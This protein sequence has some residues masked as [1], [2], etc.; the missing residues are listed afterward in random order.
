[1]F[2]FLLCR[3]K[4]PSNTLIQDQSTVGLIQKLH[5]TI[6]KP[7]QE[8]RNKTV[9]GKLSSLHG[10]NARF[11]VKKNLLL[12]FLN[13]LSNQSSS[14][15]TALDYLIKAHCAFIVFEKM[16][17]LCSLFRYCAFIYFF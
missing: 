6:C 12:L 17:A 3:K 13:Y 11:W 15:S 5:N 16:F 2:L 9:K 14:K 10:L 7:T 4:H 8:N 1:M